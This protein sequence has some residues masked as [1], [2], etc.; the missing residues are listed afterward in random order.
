[1]ALVLWPR[2]AT[3]KVRPTDPPPAAPNP[4]AAVKGARGE[5]VGVQVVL[6]SDS[7][8]TGLTPILTP[9]AGPQGTTLPATQVRLYRVDFVQVT[10][11]SDAAGA[12]GEWPDPLRPIG[13][14][15]FYN[16]DRNGAPFNLVAGR[17]QPVWIDIQIPRT[18]L[19]G[20]YS[21]S[22]QLLD[23]AG[24]AIAS[25]PVRL[26]VWAFE[27]SPTPSLPTSYGFS[28]GTA[29]AYHF[30][31][32]TP[33]TPLENQQADELTQRYLQEAAAHRITLD[34]V[35]AYIGGSAPNYDWAAWD[36]FI[37]PPG[38]SPS[39]FRVPWPP[40]LRPNDILTWTASE[41]QAA[42][43]FW[44]AAAQRYAARGWLGQNYLYTRDEP[45]T[46]GAQQIA[47][48]QSTLLHQGSPTL[49]S[50]VTHAY[51][52]A[53][54]PGNF[55]IWVPNVVL[56]DPTRAGSLPQPYLTE[57]AA[58]KRIWWY[59]SNNSDF[60]GNYPNAGGPFGR[61]PDEFIDHPGVNQ[62][63]HGPLTYRYGLEGY[64]YYNTL[65]AYS[66]PNPDPWRKQYIPQFGNNGDG[67]LFYPGTPSEI[68][69]AGGH[70]IPVPSIR[71]QILRQSWTLYDMFQMLS[72][73]GRAAD[74]QTIAANLVSNT[75]T[76]TA[77]PADFDTARE[78][79]AAAL[80]PI[81]G[82]R[83]VSDR[84]T[85]S[86]S[87]VTG[88]GTTQFPRSFYVIVDGMLPAQLGLLAIPADQAGRDAVAPTV[89]AT[90]PAG[91]VPDLAAVCEA[92]AGEGA[93]FD[94]YLVQRVTFTYT[95]RFASTAAFYLSGVGQE[96]Q[97]I[98]LTATLP[99]PTPLQATATLAL[100]RQPNPYLL[101]GPVA[102]LSEDTRVFQVSTL[103]PPPFPTAAPIP[104]SLAGARA[105]LT[106]V[107]GEFDANPTRF[108]LLPAG[109]Q[110]SQLELAP[111][112][113]QQPVFNFVIARVRYRGQT[114]PAQDV[115]VFFRLFT[116]AATGL[117]YHVNG[118]YRRSAPSG[119]AIALLGA[120]PAGALTT[121]PFFAAQRVD[122]ATQ[123]MTSQQD[124]ANVKTL[125]AGGGQETQRFFGAWLDINQL[126][127]QFPADPGA[128]PDGSWTSGR[129][130]I[131]DLIR[132]RHQCLVA[133]IYFVPTATTGDPIPEGATPAA[134]ENLAQ[135]NLM[136]VESA[137]P[138]SPDSRMVHHTLLIQPG[139]ELLPTLQPLGETEEAADERL[140]NEGPEEGPGDGLPGWT[141]DELMITWPAIPPGTH[142]RLTFGGLD[143]AD[144]V[145]LAARLGGPPILSTTDAHTLAFDAGGVTYVPL[146]GGRAAI[147][148]LFTVELPAG[149]AAGDT[150]QV[151]L[152]QM[153][154]RQR[155]V[156]SVQVLIPVRHAEEL[157]R[158]EEHTLAIFRNI[159]RSLTDDDPW[160]P[161][162]TR[163]VDQMAAR[164]RGF[165]GDPDAIRPSPWGTDRPPKR[166]GCLRWACLAAAVAALVG[167]A[168]RARRRPGTTRGRVPS[169]RR[170]H[171]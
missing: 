123:Q 76:W 21:A 34:V 170:G 140:T 97:A 149:V 78:Q 38:V 110:Q 107:L 150:Y 117:D 118:N 135:R 14:D 80:Q 155:I 167:W 143:A 86:E 40:S 126:T 112:R 49:R 152:Q 42:V 17:N 2:P 88:T 57:R 46:S 163:Y 30:Q 44:A 133:E 75:T 37:A 106:A 8:L 4:T 18:V 32:P 109:Y 36:P 62:L 159:H 31:K 24:T 15:Q 94:P 85:F 160:Q 92:I 138:G 61:W 70:H 165:G 28:R 47:I 45:N 19:P 169:R 102:W 103:N 3:V 137:N 56:L 161:V 166:V 41:R 11:P 115:R 67:T 53:L 87:E 51:D 146:T 83:L 121:I 96:Y 54:L 33:Q 151:L 111:A 90:R 162:L 100:I 66:L 122:T 43:A 116:T 64:L 13:R 6:T 82:I 74:A 134:N 124:P 93:T 129:Q 60:P 154:N 108:D 104:A 63:V 73:R 68:G 130:S 141:G 164:V 20:D 95:I 157:L 39:S 144:I 27:L 139:G 89:T 35:D 22:F 10:T 145:T 81:P 128:N 77:N 79:L 98:T 142:A 5:G 101:D 25:L 26:T 171:K 147:P 120:A 113:Q 72:E 136:I 114:V 52:A 50:L 71:L 131:Q 12:I 148:A 153:V 65:E 125:P 55:D 7:P 156:G 91:P 69:P 29:F 16:E 59:D 58:G 119:P 48:A 168:W 127:P 1:M 84:S 99:Q 158:E 105:F 23:A 132:N 9:L